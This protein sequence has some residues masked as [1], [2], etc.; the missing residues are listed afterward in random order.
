MEIGLIEGVDQELA[1]L[2]TPDTNNLFEKPTAAVVIPT[3]T[4]ILA[5]TNIAEVQALRH[6]TATYE[7]QNFIPIT[8]FL[9]QAISESIEKS[10]G[11][12]KELLL[13]VVSVIMAFDTTYDI[14]QNINKKRNKSV[15][16]YYIGFYPA[17]KDDSSIKAILLQSIK[18]VLFE[19]N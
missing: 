14:M 19:I 3:V 12:S 15:K 9:C 16:I 6:G 11:D 18:A 10:Q 17:N 13:A 5:I 2:M 4:N 1:T 7:P 8:P